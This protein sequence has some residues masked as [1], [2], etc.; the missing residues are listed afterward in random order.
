MRVQLIV[1]DFAKLINFYDSNPYEFNSGQQYSL[2][3]DSTGFQEM[4]LVD[5]KFG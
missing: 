5:W 4:N 1:A 2:R 3:T